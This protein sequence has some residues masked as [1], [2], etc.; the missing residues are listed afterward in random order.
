MDDNNDLFSAI[1]KTA[2]ERQAAVAQPKPEPVVTPTAPVTP[3][4]SVTPVVPPVKIAPAPAAKA[5]PRSTPASSGSYSAADIEVLEGLEPVRRRP[6]MYIGGTDERALHHLFAEVIDNAMDEAVAGHANFIDIDLEENGYLSVTDNG[7]G[8]PIDP[9]P[10]FKDK[11]A[12]EVIMTTLHSGGKFDSKVYETSGGLHGVGVSVVNALS[13]HVEVEVALNRRLYRQR[14]SRGHPLGPLEDI[15]E[16]HN[17]RGTRVTFHPDPD[18]FGQGAKFDPARLFKMARSKAYL[19]GGVEI[20]WNCAPSLLDPKDPTPDKAVFHFPGGLKDY[21]GA[22]L[23]KDFQV[24]REMFS[25]KTEKASGHGALEWAVAWYG[26][27]GFVN[28]Y[29]NTIPTGEGGTHEAGLRIALTRG[30]KAYAELTGNKRASIITTDDV[31]ISSAA[32]L[33]VFI[34]EPEFVGQT[35]DKLATVEAQRIVE[36]AIR[37]PFDHWLAASPQEASKLLEWVVERAD[38][39]VKRRQ[40][41]EVN[42]KSAVRKLRLP[43]KLADCSQTGALGAELFIVEGDSAGG[44]A[45]QARDRAT[46]AVL[47]LR[48]KILNVVSAGREKMTANQQIGDL[49]LALGCGTRSKYRDEDLRYDRVIIMT[50][51]DVDGAHIASLL[52]TF[53][54]QEMPD[55]IRNGHLFLGVPPLYRIAQGGKVAYARDDAHKDE[56]MRT[57]FTGKGKIEIG[58]FKGLGEMRADQLKE[59]TMDRK[60]RTLLRVQIDEEWIEETRVAVDDLMGTKPEA[61]FRFIQDRAAFVEELDI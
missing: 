30:L 2:R 50:D 19:F 36:N 7:R 47:P 55:L 16:V 42:R 53:F 54:Y 37:D 4:T 34:R 44:S 28:S 26:G 14:F 56:L 17:R 21:L 52:I 20:R 8:I 23:G 40:E 35:K 58:R 38:E 6:G 27:D 51:A 25:G 33:S 15:G 45:K 9:H 29:C 12:L 31:M 1:V 60:K 11:S 61:R 39:R 10:K 46:Q 5:S 32:M 3:V 48:G 49:I 41:K 43:G 24:T 13:D 57:L 22:S 59:T 18:I